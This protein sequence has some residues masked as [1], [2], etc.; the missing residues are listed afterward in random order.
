MTKLI[1]IVLA[2]ALGLSAQITSIPSAAGAAPGGA[3]GGATSLTTVGAIPVV[4]AAG[5]L[6]ETGIIPITP[7]MY[8]AVGNGVHD[9]TVAITAAKTVACA[10]AAA[11]DVRGATLYFPT[12]LVY[13]LV[14]ATIPLCSSLEVAG[15]MAKIHYTG[16]GSLFTLPLS[17]DGSIHGMI[18]EGTE[19]A[20]VWAI[21]ISGTAGNGAAVERIYNNKFYLWGDLATGSGGGDPKRRRLRESHHLWELLLRKWYGRGEH[22][23][24]GLRHNSPQQI[25]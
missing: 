11:G 19:A 22:I 1:T 15:D 14:S 21:T 17:V 20:S 13:Y 8:G 25:L 24:N 12:P 2:G 4:T 9:D 10:I 5:V 3:V 7:Q 6:G 16:T 18:L 23:R